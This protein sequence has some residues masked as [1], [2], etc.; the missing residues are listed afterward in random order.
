MPLV[1]MKKFGLIGAAGFIAPRHMDAINSIGGELITACD[2]SDSVGIL[3]RY[4]PKCSFCTNPDEWFMDYL[5]HVDTI[6]VCTPNHL[7][8]LHAQMG[9]NA[10][11][12]IIL[13]KPISIRGEGYSSAE[14][15]CATMGKFRHVIY[16]VVQLRYHPNVV[17]LKNYISGNRGKVF[18]CQIDYTA[19]RGP[20]YQKSWKGDEEKSGGLL[21]NLGVHLVD[22]CCHM[23]G[24]FLHPIESHIG[25]EESHGIFRCEH[26]TVSWKLATND[27]N[28]RRVFKVAGQELDLSNGMKSLH[29]TFYEHVSSG[30][31]FTLEDVSQSIHAIDRI[32]MQ[33][34]S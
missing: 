32:K 13:E 15:L 25:K 24:P 9:L 29:R 28:T 2:L 19:Y 23:F 14:S 31:R 26:A 3:D 22:L 18:H 16:P 21:V 7:H 12:N 20:W 33:A 6:V 4:A 30:D 27:M 5:R 34:K 1:K 8:G 10:G 17:E 11:C